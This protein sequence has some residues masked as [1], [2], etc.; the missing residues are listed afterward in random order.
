MRKTVLISSIVLGAVALIAAGL[1]A[2]A[3][4]NLSALIARNQDRILARVSGEL[5]RQVAVGKIQAQVGWG[6][7]V[8]VSGLTIADDP[9]FSSKPFLAASDV[10]VHV[11]FLPL[12]AGEARV[13]RLELSKPDIR[14]VM[15]ANGDLNVASIG[16]S[17]GEAPEVKEQ[18]RRTKKSSLADLSIRALSIEDGEFYFTDLSE[19]AVP[20]R[21]HH[22]DFDVTNFNAASAFDVETKFAFPGDTQNVEA[23]G[24]L[25]PLLNQGVLDASGIPIDLTLKLD[26]IVL[27]SLRPL[28]DIGP[29]IPQGLSIPDAASINGTAHGTVATLAIALSTDLTANRVAY[30]TIFNKPAGT[31]MTVNVNGSW[32]DQLQIASVIL[33]LSD[34]ELTASRISGVTGPQPLSAQID[35]NSFNLANLGPMINA[36]AEYS[37]AGTGEVHGTVT[38]NPNAPTVDG[39]VTLK[40]AALKLGPSVSIPAACVNSHSLTQ[41]SQ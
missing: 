21:V 14:L 26:S 34:L 4:F 20:I 38:L 11:E 16:A 17:P 9:A 39:T 40:Q 41:P 19:K 32:G 27:G 5:G 25:G 28:A 2:Y 22:L 35:S 24:K 3:Y 8:D 31:A 23:S 30:T 7:S 33:K 10:K 12:L 13:S 1:A 36:V 29:Q 18:S 6:V 37:V 15:N